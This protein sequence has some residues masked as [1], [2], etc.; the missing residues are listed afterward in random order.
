MGEGATRLTHE[1]RGLSR[2]SLCHHLHPLVHTFIRSHLHT[3][4]L[5][6]FIR[7][8]VRAERNEGNEEQGR[9]YESLIPPFLIPPL[10]FNGPM[11]FN[12]TYLLFLLPPVPAVLNTAN[13]R[14]GRPQ[15]LRARSRTLL[16]M[17]GT[18]RSIFLW[19]WTCAAQF[20][21]LAI[22]EPSTTYARTRWP[23]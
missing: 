4:T 18:K 23:A 12:L 7:P 13:R 2:A 19:P 9:P 1:P 14:H 11:P 6:P 15:R 21:P 8:P 17:T 16:H 3:S 20:L 22:D 5:R 10:F